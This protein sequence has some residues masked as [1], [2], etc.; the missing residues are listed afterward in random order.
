MGVA[1]SMVSSS[2]RMYNRGGD[3]HA[4]D[5]VSGVVPPSERLKCWGEGGTG[6]GT[7]W[8]L[9]LPSDR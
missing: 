2:D 4:M 7:A 8:R 5:V 1:S 9:A 6:L 3:A